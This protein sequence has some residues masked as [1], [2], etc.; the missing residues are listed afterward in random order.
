VTLDFG[1]PDNPTDNAFVESFSGR[2]PD[3]CLNAHWF[4]SLAGGRAKIEGRRG[5]YNEPS[6]HIAWLADAS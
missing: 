6:S 3:E 1:R 2:L 5:A 4:L